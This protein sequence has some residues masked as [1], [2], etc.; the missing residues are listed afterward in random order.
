MQQSWPKATLMPGPHL[1]HAGLA[2]A[3]GVAVVAALQHDIDQRIR[4]RGNAGFA[5][6]GSSFET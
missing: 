4:D 6:S 2:A 1:R 5:I 3:L